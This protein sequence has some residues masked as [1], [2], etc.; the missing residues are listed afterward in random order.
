MKSSH[1]PDICDALVQ[2]TLGPASR[3]AQE[4]GTLLREIRR[5]NKTI[6]VVC[7]LDF[8]CLCTKLCLQSEICG[9]AKFWTVGSFCVLVSV[10]T[11]QN[12]ARAVFGSRIV[13][14]LMDCVC[15]SSNR[16]QPA[17]TLTRLGTVFFKNCQKYSE[18]AKQ[19]CRIIAFSCLQ[20]YTAYDFAK[21]ANALL[22]CCI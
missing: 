5:T 16:T 6:Q 18:V 2:E 4:E 7:W 12:N 22:C 21:D 3:E 13:G 10:R 20:L 11:Q 19:L 9:C 8:V 15:T 17:E 1:R 14:V